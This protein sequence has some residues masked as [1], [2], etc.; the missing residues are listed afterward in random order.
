M[1]SLN[2]Q[3]GPVINSKFAEKLGLGVSLMERM[4][5]KKR[6]KNCPSYDNNYII[7]LLDNYR[8]HPAILHFP[9]IHFYDSK[10]RAKASQQTGG[11]FPIVFH[12]TKEPS[13]IE[14]KGTSSYNDTEVK[15]V[16]SYVDDLLR[17]G[18]NQLD[19]GII[20]PYKAQLSKLRTI[21][22]K[23]TDIEIGTAEYYQGREKNVIIISTVKSQSSVGFLKSEKVGLIIKLK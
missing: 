18:L 10:L 1:L 15:I 22:G 7:Q 3:L 5:T 9:N 19:I 11:E 12:C 21:L 16:K 8:N 13:R 20:S 17:N 6:Y 4:M 23:L 14:F 2:R